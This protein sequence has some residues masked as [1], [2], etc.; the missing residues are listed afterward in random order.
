MLREF[1]RAHGYGRGMILPATDVFRLSVPAVSSYA[2]HMDKHHLAGVRRRRRSR[3]I[4]AAVLHAE[5]PSLESTCRLA[6]LSRS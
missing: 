5:L 4:V 1:A 2:A 3:E 6:R